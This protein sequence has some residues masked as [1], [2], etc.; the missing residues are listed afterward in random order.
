MT[1]P[2]TPTGAPGVEADSVAGFRAIGL[3][4]SRVAPA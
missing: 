4:L 2:G 1:T 3:L